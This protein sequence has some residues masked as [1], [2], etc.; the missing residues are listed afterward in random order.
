MKAPKEG[1]L[2]GTTGISQICTPDISNCYDISYVDSISQQTKFIRAHIAPGYYIDSLGYL[3]EVPYGNKASADLRSYSP[4]S[5]KTQQY[6]NASI[7]Q[8]KVIDLSINE[9]EQQIN[10]TPRPDVIVLQKLQQQLI[11]L[12]QQKTDIMYLNDTSNNAYNSDNIDMT[13]HADPETKQ[14]GDTSIDG[15]GEV[16][17]NQ[18]GQ[19]VSLPYQD[20]SN[21]T[22]YYEP[23]T[24]KFNS[25]SYVPNYEESV[26]LSKMTNDIP[27]ATAT[28]SKNAMNFCEDTQSSQIERE[29]RCNELDGPMCA[30]TNC[31]VLLGGE[32]CVAGGREGPSNKTHYSD[33]MLKNS[34]YYYYKK[35]CYGNCVGKP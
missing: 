33:I 28:A 9:I 18:G 4:Y 13:Y 3:K 16:W 22:L 2:T 27:Y 32:K 23:G 21:T 19:L 17:V 24:Y 26:L 30:S 6:A 35:K 1:F 11:N 14:F 8:N 10:A 12:K 34:D 7:N 5:K 31:C 15:I 20:I 25:A 29:A